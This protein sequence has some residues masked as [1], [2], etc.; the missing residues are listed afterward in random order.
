[1]H[2]R[3]LIS[4]KYF[5]EIG[6]KVSWEMILKKLNLPYKKRKNGNILLLCPF[7]KE[8]TPSLILFE[9]SWIF[10]CFGCGNEGTKFSFIRIFFAGQNGRAI[11][12][13]KKHWEISVPGYIPPKKKKN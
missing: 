12:F 8:R 3:N 10:H 1:M 2:G 11:K 4:R 9:N 5:E 7:H 6:K 13:F